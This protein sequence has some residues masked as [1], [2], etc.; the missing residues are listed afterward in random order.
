MI[1]VRFIGGLGNQMYQ[2]ALMN[3]LKNRYPNVEILADTSLYYVLDPHYGFELDKVFSLVSS[4][5]MKIATNKQ[6]FRMR[7]QIP[8]NSGKI[9]KLMQKPTG[10]I[11]GR[12]LLKI[13]SHYDNIISEVEHP[14]LESTARLND[15]LN[16]LDVNRDWCVDGYWQQEEYFEN[17]LPQ[18]VADFKFPDL[19]STQELDMRSKICASNSVSVHIRRGD[20]TNTEYDIL[21]IEYYKKAISYMFDHVEKPVF[22]FF[23]EDEQY[24]EENFAW[25]RN[26]VNVT[27]NRGCNS[28]RDMQLMSLCK[29]NIVA[30]SSFSNWAAYL[31]SNSDKI[32]VYPGRY[33]LSDENS[34]KKG[35]I[36]IDT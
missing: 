27:F 36:R 5:K 30:N 24:V 11:N 19:N 3:V 1:I 9:G 10:W 32:V 21:G 20:Y 14:S 16:N 4:G 34:I 8:F 25:V 18:I 28:Y 12:V 13:Y 33:T 29:H 31:N 22:F 23:S 7:H 17:S 6:L 26:K 15:V 2:Y 35:W